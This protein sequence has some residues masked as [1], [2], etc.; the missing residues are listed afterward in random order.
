MS[1]RRNTG[2]SSAEMNSACGL[3]SGVPSF[4]STGKISGRRRRLWPKAKV[5]NIPSRSQWI[6][7]LTV[8]DN[9]VS[10][11][12]IEIHSDRM[13]NGALKNIR[14][15]ASVFWNGKDIVPVE[16]GMNI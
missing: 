11:A 1:G 9:I 6:S 16:I 3:N 2:F 10:N 5:L 15:L 13:K 4:P 12:N 7:F 8:C 14:V